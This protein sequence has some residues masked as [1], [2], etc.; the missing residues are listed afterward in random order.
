MPKRPA[1]EDSQPPLPQSKR[2][3]PTTT[4]WDRLRP[5]HYRHAC[6]PFQRPIEIAHFSFDGQRQLH[7]DDRQ[8]KFYY[9]PD[10]NDPNACN[11]S[12]GY[13]DKYE[14]RDE[15]IPEHLDA[16]LESLKELRLRQKE[17]S[18]TVHHETDA[19]FVTWRGIMTRVYI[20][21]AIYI[22]YRVNIHMSVLVFLLSP[23]LLLLLTQ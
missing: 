10:M 11:L 5:D 13:P 15:S 23:V 1:V 4:I 7:H 18:E 14:Q 19:D 12:A 8:L 6:V 17:Q 16:L 3:A 2:L 21:Q 22:S 9:P 20:F